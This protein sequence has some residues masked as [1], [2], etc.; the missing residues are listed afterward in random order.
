MLVWLGLCTVQILMLESQ[1]V[2]LYLCICFYEFVFMHSAT[3][4]SLNHSLARAKS[5]RHKQ[6]H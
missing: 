1:L 6:R 5:D 2:A 3:I 4:A